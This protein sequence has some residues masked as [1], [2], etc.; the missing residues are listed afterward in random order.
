[1]DETDVNDLP[2][3][4]ARALELTLSAP[5]EE[6]WFRGH[7][8]SSWAVASPFVVFERR[9]VSSVAGS[10]LLDEAS[11]TATAGPQGPL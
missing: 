11:E 1:M 9:E 4:V 8:R 7:G 10:L 2:E 3:L 6:W 5:D